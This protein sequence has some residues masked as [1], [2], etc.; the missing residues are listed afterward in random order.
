[1]PALPTP[2]VAIAPS[3]IP[4]PPPPPAPPAPP[5]ATPPRVAPPT[6]VPPPPV[7]NPSAAPSRTSQ[8]N[9]T[10]NPAPE[11]DALLN[12]LEKLRALQPQTKPPT[13]RYNPAAGG[14]PNAGGSPDGD[15][16]AL[17]AR[18]MGAI[19]DHVRECW[20]HDAGALGADKLQVRLRVLTDET[21][22]ARQA[23]VIGADLARMGD[24]VFRAFAERARRA[25]LDP[26]CANLPLPGTLLGQRRTLDFRFSP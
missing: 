17:S 16:N 14:A 24:P 8:P 11:S 22:V 15:T 7:P 18:Q 23:D 6:T 12:T 20:A 13:A 10:K 5:Q 3:L 2:P 25:V 4:L 19:G 1:V 21:G 26:R 9:A